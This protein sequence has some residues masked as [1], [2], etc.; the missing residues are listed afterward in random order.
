MRVLPQLA[1]AIV[2]IT[3]AKDMANL[4]HEMSTQ[5]ATGDATLLAETHAVSAGLKSYVSSHV[6]DS[7][8]V[9]RRALGGHGFLDSAGV[10]KIFARE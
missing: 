10:G 8:E 6:V 9:L 2:F 7:T 5:L 3:A 1:K 4:Y